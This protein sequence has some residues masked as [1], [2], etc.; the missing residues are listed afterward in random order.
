[1]T[2]GSYLKTHPVEAI[3]WDGTKVG[4]EQILAWVND[5]QAGYVAMDNPDR[6]SG[7]H[8]RIPGAARVLPGDWV[9]HDAHGFTRCHMDQF[10]TTYELAAPTGNPT[11]DDQ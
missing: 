3:Q 2:P 10:W 4:A 8:I 9:I 7:A 6:G 11:E 5:Q 1:M